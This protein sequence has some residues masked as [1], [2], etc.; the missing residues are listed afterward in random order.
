MELNNFL[1]YGILPLLALS[2]LFIVFRLLRGPSIPDRIVSLDLMINSGIAIIVI[3]SI[4]NDQ[5]AFL[6][7]AMVLALIAFLGTLSFTYYL[8][9]KNLEGDD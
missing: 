8:K 6:D 1:T 5:P 9:Q 3:Y 2:L 4:I 7:I